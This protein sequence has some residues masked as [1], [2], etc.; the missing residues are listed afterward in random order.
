MNDMCRWWVSLVTLVVVITA[1]LA[2]SS[3]REAHMNDEDQLTQER[4]ASTQLEK[5]LRQRLLLTQID[6]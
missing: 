1:Q 6:R 2:C 3:N 5:E 4:Q